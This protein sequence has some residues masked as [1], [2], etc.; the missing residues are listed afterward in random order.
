MVGHNGHLGDSRWRLRWPVPAHA[1]TKER[2]TAAYR[3]RGSVVSVRVA[4]RNDGRADQLRGADAIRVEVGV[5][6]RQCPGASAGLLCPHA[7]ERVDRGRR[8]GDRRGQIARTTFAKIDTVRGVAGADNVED[9]RRQAAATLLADEQAVYNVVFGMCGGD[10][11]IQ[12]AVVGLTDFGP[13]AGVA[14]GDGVGDEY[15]SHCRRRFRGC[16]HRQRRQAH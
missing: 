12:I 9:A 13:I 10:L 6:D 14:V 8:V 3:C 15:G 5:D 2:A 11:G 1:A 7:N 4:L 16:G